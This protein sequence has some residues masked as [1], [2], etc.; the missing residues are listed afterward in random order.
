MPGKRHH[1]PTCA[2]L[3]FERPCFEMVAKYSLHVKTVFQNCLF[4]TTLP[5]IPYTPLSACTH[6]PYSRRVGEGGDNG[7]WYGAMPWQNDCVLK[8]CVLN[9]RPYL[10]LFQNTVFQNTVLCRLDICLHMVTFVMHILRHT[11]GD[12]YI[13]IYIYI[14]I[15]FCLAEVYA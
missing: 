11:Y 13:Y 10:L 3:S 4:V 7:V 8:D 6:L 1:T 14:Y 2:G 15:D 5:Y 9:W 12:I